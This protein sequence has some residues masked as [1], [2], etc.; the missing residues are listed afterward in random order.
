MCDPASN[1]IA[2]VL[3]GVGEIVGGVAN[4]AVSVAL[5]VVG[6]LLAVGL[7]VELIVAIA[8]PLMIATGAFA[9]IMA[10]VLI[11]MRQAAS[12]KR[13]AASRAY[14]PAPAL[15]LT[16][17]KRLGQSQPAIGPARRALPPAQRSAPPLGALVAEAQ[18]VNETRLP[19]PYF[20]ER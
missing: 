12:P 1:P 9:V 6:G 8:V 3:G 4:V 19:R 5:P 17:Q 10:G 20:G 16:M 7:A 14:V 13:F 18:L 2:D 11:A 15:P